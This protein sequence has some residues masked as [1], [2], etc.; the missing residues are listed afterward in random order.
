[1]SSLINLASYKITSEKQLSNNYNLLVDALNSNFDFTLTQVSDPIPSATIGKVKDVLAIKS[2]FILGYSSLA[3]LISVPDI[4]NKFLSNTAQSIRLNNNLTFSLLNDAG[5]SNSLTV[6]ATLPGGTAANNVTFRQLS[7]V[8]DMEEIHT[9]TQFTVVANSGSVNI[10]QGYFQINALKV[11][12]Y[13]FPTTAPQNGQVLQAFDGNLEFKDFSMHVNLYSN[14]YQF[15]NKY[16]LR[17]SLGQFSTSASGLM[18][19]FGGEENGIGYANYGYSDNSKRLFFRVDA[20]EVLEIVKPRNIGNNNIAAY[21]QFNCGLALASSK[22]IDNLY[23]P[24]GALWYEAGTESL[25]LT[26]ASGI[27]YI[28]SQSF[29]GAVN[30]EEVKDFTLNAA[31][32][33]RVDKGSTQKPAFNIGDNVGL[34]SDSTSLKFVVNGNPAVQISDVGIESATSSSTATAKITLDDSIGINNSNR[35]TYSFSGANGLGIFRA[36]TDVIGMAVKG[37]T[38]LE[39]AEEKLNLKGNKVTNIA[40]PTE[41]QDAVN[42]EYVDNLIPLGFIAGSLPIVSSGTV[43][44]YIQSDA[45][46]LNGVLEIGNS[47]NPA[48]LKMNSGG[49]GV[50]I[51]KAPNTVNNIIFELPSNNLNNGILQNVSGQSRWV[52]IDSI[53]GNILKADGSVSLSKGLNLTVSSTPQNPAIGRGNTGVYATTE[54]ASKVGFSAQGQRLLEANASS[55][56]LVGI[57]DTFNAPFIRLYNTITN[58]SS[59][60][61]AQPTYAFAGESETGLGQ[62]KVQSVSL[63]VNGVEK[64]SANVNGIDVHNNRVQAVSDPIQK[65]DAATKGYVDSSIKP[66]KEFGFLVQNLPT[67]WVSGSGGALILSIYDK[68]LIFGSAAVSLV[69]ES[70]TDSKLAVVPSNFYINPECQVYVDGVRINKMAKPNGIREVSYG[71]SGSIVL[72]YDLY[73]GAIVTIHLPG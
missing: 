18:L 60:G 25:V 1:M 23:N 38:I 56:A 49:G 52:S 6:A 71:T 20:E 50:A 37:K 3:D 54:Q 57:G 10:S 66:R 32:T 47:A 67:G 73:I 17:L 64:L 61:S 44:K 68:V 7:N 21:I 59:I 36:D 8:G 69:Y 39:V 33:L 65:T 22:L 45:K 12:T 72:N 4:F 11:G 55:R 19:K 63:F 34:I 35:P 2:G 13:Q 40:T 28:S 26:T 41:S 58:Y 9:V 42:K 30:T 15:E 51:I 43:S 14:E 29:T 62:T 46:Y 5:V 53:T 27:R 70:A 24:V 48:S 31:S 16:P